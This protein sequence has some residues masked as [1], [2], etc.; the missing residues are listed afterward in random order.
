[1]RYVTTYHHPFAWDYYKPTLKYDAIDPQFTRLYTYPHAT[2]APSSKEFQ[3]TW[4]ANIN[5]VLKNTI[6]ILPTL[7]SGFT[8]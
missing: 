6:F 5:E 1:M 3:E 4:L 7:T 8:R 2:E